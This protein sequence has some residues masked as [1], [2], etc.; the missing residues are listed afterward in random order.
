MPFM[1]PITSITTAFA[2]LFIATAAISHAQDTTRIIP[3]DELVRAWSLPSKTLFTSTPASTIVRKAQVSPK[4]AAQIGAPATAPTAKPKRGI[5]ITPA[6]GSA[7]ATAAIPVAQ[8]SAEHFRNLLFNFSDITFKHPRIALQQLSAIATAMNRLDATFLL[9]GHT[10]S[11]GDEPYNQR[12]SERRARE[13]RRRLTED[14]GVSTEKLIA[15][16]F[17]ETDPFT[18]N[19]HEVG[20]IQ[21]RRVTIFRIEG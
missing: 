4:A 18:A 20:R 12:L 3:A 13:I 11:R 14:F 17:G 8:Q 6:R 16:G 5:Q 19:T 9:E 1:N 2:A 21:N 15:V 10:C 7:L